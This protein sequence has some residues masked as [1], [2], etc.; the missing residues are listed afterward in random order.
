[1]TTDDEE[2]VCLTAGQIENIGKAYAKEIEGKPIKNVCPKASIWVKGFF[3]KKKQKKE[4][5]TVNKAAG[6]IERKVKNKI[7]SALGV[8]GDLF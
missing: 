5:D 6:K 4:S 3:G 8:L 2:K 7:K 1:M